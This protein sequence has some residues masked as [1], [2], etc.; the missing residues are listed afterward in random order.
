MLLRSGR[1]AGFRIAPVQRDG[2]HEA[3]EVAEAV[4]ASFEVPADLAAGLD[5]AAVG[6]SHVHDDHVGL[7]AAGFGHGLLDAAGFADDFNVWLQTKNH[8][9]SFADYRVIIHNDNVTPMDFVVHILKTCFYLSNPQ[10]ADIMLTAHVYGS[11]YVQTLAKSEAD[12]ELRD[13]K[14]LLEDRTGSECLDFCYPWGKHDG[15]AVAAVKA[16]GYMNAVIAIQGRWRK[17]ESPDMYRVPRAD[18]RRDYS[19]NDFAAVVAGDWDYLKYL[20]RFRR[21]LD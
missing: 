11:A 4:G 7:G 10:A 5:A 13:S 9:Q 19:L 2:C 21:L 12:A 20:Q 15:R 17:N 14:R 6:Q 8:G 1:E 18:V 16:A 3:F